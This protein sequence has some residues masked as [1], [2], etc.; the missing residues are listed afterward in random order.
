MKTLFRVLLP[1]CLA[2]MLNACSKSSNGD[3]Y[4]NNNPP[5]SNP[6]STSNSI[7]ISMMQFSPA[8]THVPVGTTVTWTNNDNM[9]HTVTDTGGS[10]DSG[11]FGNGQKF[12]YTFKTK[13]TFNY[14]CTIH[15][16][17][18]GKVVVE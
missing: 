9:N 1:L 4:G 10:F 16:N 6:P 7:T 15:T 11:P 18:Q 17:M 8:E 12:S 5:P 13:G 14:K 3:G 2:C